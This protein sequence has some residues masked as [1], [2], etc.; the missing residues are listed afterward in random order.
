MKVKF[1]FDV[2]ALITGVEIESRSYG[3]AKK[4][5]YQMTL[6]EL[7]GEGNTK[8][9]TISDVNGLIIEK[10][11]KIKVY[12][13]EYNIEEDDYESPEEYTRII[14]SLPTDLVVELTVEPIDSLEDLIANEITYKTDWLVSQFKYIIIEEK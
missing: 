9:F 4:I 3:A 5:L 6:E 2:N 14:N 11:L 7:L 1:D 10:T 13:I 12:D 8:N